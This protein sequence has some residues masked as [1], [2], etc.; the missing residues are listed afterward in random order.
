MREA[1]IPPGIREGE[2]IAR[3]FFGNGLR[4]TMRCDAQTASEDEEE[5]EVGTTNYFLPPKNAASRSPWLAPRRK[6]EGGF[7]FAVR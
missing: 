5:D 6:E 2:V 1:S 3:H 7:P 4:G